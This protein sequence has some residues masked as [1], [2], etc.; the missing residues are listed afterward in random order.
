MAILYNL[1]ESNLNAL[2]NAIYRNQYDQYDFSGIIGNIQALQ[3]LLNVLTLVV[4]I[5]LVFVFGLY[6]WN[7]GLSTTLSF[8]QPI[9]MGRYQQY[10]NKYAQLLVTLFALL[11]IF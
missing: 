5:I 7:Q 1:I 11:L 9:G 6:L 10:G 2:L 4:Y 8:V 3:V